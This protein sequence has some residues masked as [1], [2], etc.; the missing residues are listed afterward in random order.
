MGTTGAPAEMSEAP[1]SLGA[2]LV[3]VFFSPGETFEDIARKPDWIAPLVLMTIVSIAGM[4]IFLNKIG[5]R[6]IIEWA[7]EHSKNPQTLPPEQLDRAAQIQ[8]LF[9]HA[10]GVLATP[11]EALALAGIGLLIV[12]VILGGKISFKT[13]F[14]VACYANVVTIVGAIVGVVMVLAGGPEHIISNPQ[15]PTPLSLGFFLDPLETSKPLLSL[16]G[17]IDVMTFWFMGMLGVGYS[18]AAGGKVK[19]A[20]VFL[21][22]LA[23]WIVW[24]LIKMGLSTLGS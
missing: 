13:A 17:S 16:G 10:L 18:R 8:T 1:K 9:F 5:V 6:P 14:A 21:I 24:V 4:E 3:G 2:R 12:N 15:N 19:T 7:L 23:I 22:F 11:V 20:S